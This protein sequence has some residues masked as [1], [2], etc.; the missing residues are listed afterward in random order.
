MPRSLLISLC[1]GA[2]ILVAFFIAMTSSDL[3]KPLYDKLRSLAQKVLRLDTKSDP[4]VLYYHEK[5]AAFEQDP[6]TDYTV[7]FIGDSLTDGGDWEQF[8]DADTIANRGI[9]GD[10]AIGILQ[11]MKPIIRTGAQQAF[12]MVGV[13]DVRRSLSM[14]E[15]VANYRNIVSQLMAADIQVLIQS[16]VLTAKTDTPEINSRINALN[17]QLI[18][19]AKETP[20][21]TFIDIN[22]DLAPSGQLDK[23]YTYDGIH[24]NKTGYEVWQKQ[25]APFMKL[26]KDRF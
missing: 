26:E 6:R 2:A 11:R 3:K 1:V 20:K 19:L 24:L 15:I 21:V 12:I 9:N 25:I 8:F 7:V 14:D 13:N 23:N 18:K 5:V 4:N 16:T 10:T 17:T 22:T